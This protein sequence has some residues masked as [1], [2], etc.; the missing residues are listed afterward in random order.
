MRCWFHSL[1]FLSSL[2]WIK[3]RYLHFWFPCA[4]KE[5]YQEMLHLHETQKAGNGYALIGL[6]LCIKTGIQEWGTE[7]GERG[8]EGECYIP[9]NTLKHSGECRQTFRG[10][11]SNIRG[12]VVKHSRE[13]RQ[14]LRGMS[15]N[16]PGIV[17][18]HSWECSKTFRGC[19][20]TFRGV[21]PNIPRNVAKHSGECRQIFRGMS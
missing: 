6:R 11:S 18:K 3:N 13:C 16:I 14:K 7:C 9:G 5:I 21:S 15:S 1:I 4:I 8:E 17:P 10:I 20:K 12:N 19:C 2:L